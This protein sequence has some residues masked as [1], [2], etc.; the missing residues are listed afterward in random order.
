MDNHLNALAL[1]QM[2]ARQAFADRLASIPAKYV[3]SFGAMAMAAENYSKSMA[4]SNK[5]SFFQKL[6][7]IQITYLFRPCFRIV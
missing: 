1:E 5:P 2:Q 4:E 6:I 7:N 3:G